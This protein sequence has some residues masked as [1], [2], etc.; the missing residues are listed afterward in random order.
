MEPG[1]TCLLVD[2][3]NVIHAWEFLS[4]LNRDAPRRYQAREELIRILSDHCSTAGYH[5]VIVFDGQ[6]KKSA[7]SEA[8]SVPG[9]QV[10]YTRS[11]QTADDLIEQLVRKYINR[12]RLIVATGDRME[13]DTVVSLGA[14]VV[15]P[16]QL[17]AEVEASGGDRSQYLRW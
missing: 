10:F 1:K 4:D 17:E 15:S 14:E 6:G 8:E 11:G 16:K 7:L 3:H 5:G 13:Q 12:Y 9:L 2:G